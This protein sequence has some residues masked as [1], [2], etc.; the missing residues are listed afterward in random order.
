MTE[1]RNWI[2][3]G[4]AAAELSGPTKA[5]AELYLRKGGGDPLIALVVACET[6]GVMAGAVSRGMVRGGVQREA[7]E[8]ALSTIE[9]AQ[10]P[11]KKRR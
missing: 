9:R 6:I 1:D 10:R 5:L 2:L 8:E 11:I 7:L 4:P 3:G